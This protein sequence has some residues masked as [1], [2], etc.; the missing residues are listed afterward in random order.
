MRLGV[1]NRGLALLVP[2]SC[3]CSI[4]SEGLL[5]RFRLCLFLLRLRW[6][7]RLGSASHRPTTYVSALAS[8]LRRLL[9]LNSRAVQVRAA[10][11][12]RIVKT[13]GSRRLLSELLRSLD[14]I[15]RVSFMSQAATT[16]RTVLNY[17]HLR[18][19]YLDKVILVPPKVSIAFD[20]SFTFQPFLVKRRFRQLPAISF[21]ITFLI[22]PGQSTVSCCIVFMGLRSLW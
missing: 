1:F 11:N 15:D 17:R 2:D 18:L 20:G 8:L 16:T 12:R 22:L 6:H 14:R 7:A 19:V 21:C 5:S 9:P 3:Y 13:M 4:L 10:G